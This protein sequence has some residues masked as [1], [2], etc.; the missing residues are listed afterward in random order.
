MAPHMAFSNKEKVC[1]DSWYMKRMALLSSELLNSSQ[2]FTFSCISVEIKAWCR[3]P[4]RQGRG[5]K[6][7][8]VPHM[9]SSTKEQV[10]LD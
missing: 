5:L 7:F 1:F 8:V 10:C 4:W 6:L 3:A 2:I 9:A